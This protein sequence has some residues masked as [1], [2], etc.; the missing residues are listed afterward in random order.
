[1]FLKNEKGELVNINKIAAVT[2]NTNTRGVNGEIRHFMSTHTHHGKVVR[3]SYKTIDEF[4]RSYKDLQKLLIKGVERG[5]QHWTDTN[6]KWVCANGA[7][8]HIDQLECIV[9]EGGAV[10]ACLANSEVKFWYNSGEELFKYLNAFE[11]N[12]RSAGHLIDLNDWKVE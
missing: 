6:V 1:M 10:K 11:F 12:L 7:M 2:T 5:S 8:L 4:T 3:F 9:F